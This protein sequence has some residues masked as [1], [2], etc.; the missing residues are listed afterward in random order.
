MAKAVGGGGDQEESSSLRQRN[1]LLRRGSSG[2]GAGRDR[3]A[4]GESGNLVY[5]QQSHNLKEPCA[6]YGFEIYELGLDDTT[7]QGVCLRY[8]ISARALGRLN[9]FSG[10]QWERI[11]VVPARSAESATE[12]ALALAKVLA[13]SRLS[14]ICKDRAR[15]ILVEACWDWGKARS[16][17][18]D[19]AQLA[20]LARADCMIAE[21]ASTSS[22]HARQKPRG[23]RGS[24]DSVGGGVH[25]EMKRWRKLS[26]DFQQ[27]LGEF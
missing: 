2:G 10:C 17:A 25:I 1:G 18:L 22:K 13:I 15:D 24:R 4:G 12:E 27:F 6:P 26:Q 11:L 8:K 21:K 5:A 20:L 16:M 14:G 23:R 3:V 9:N 7:L 19:I